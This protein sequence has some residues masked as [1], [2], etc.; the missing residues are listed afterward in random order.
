MQLAKSWTLPISI[1]S[2]LTATYAIPWNFDNV[3]GYL[4][5]TTIFP[6]LSQAVIAAATAVIAFL[7]K[8]S[9]LPLQIV[10]L[11]VA[12]VNTFSFTFGFWGVVLPTL[13]KVLL[14][15][16]TCALIPVLIWGRKTVSASKV[17]ADSETNSFKTD[18]SNW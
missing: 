16:T 2:G 12:T 3:D 8:S 7:G 6:L 17:T 14:V 18:N 1:M 15:L 9:W 11:V 4:V 13:P 10:L 5:F